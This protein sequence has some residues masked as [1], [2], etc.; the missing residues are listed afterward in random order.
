MDMKVD[1]DIR[2]AACH[3]EYRFREFT[4]SCPQAK[5]QMR[6]SLEQHARF[7]KNPRARPHLKARRVNLVNPVNKFYQKFQSQISPQII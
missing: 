3:I 5:P 6:V 1:R 4:R 2:I 7:W